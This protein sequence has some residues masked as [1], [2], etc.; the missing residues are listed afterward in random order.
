MALVRMLIASSLRP[1]MRQRT[2]TNY[3]IPATPTGSGSAGAIE[4]GLERD[5]PPRSLAA[6]AGALQG[7]WGGR[8][9]VV[10]AAGHSGKGRADVGMGKIPTDEEEGFIEIFRQGVGE[11]V[12]EVQLRGVPGAPAE[13]AMSVAGD[14][15]LFGSHGLDDD[16]KVVDEII[17]SYLRPWIGVSICHDRCFEEIGSGHPDYRRCKHGVEVP[18]VQ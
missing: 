7:D 2:R 5:V 12:A 11:A 18:L 8:A 1:G 3:G 17:K 14:A 9:T 13:A 16:P 6:L 15:R 4:E 10:G